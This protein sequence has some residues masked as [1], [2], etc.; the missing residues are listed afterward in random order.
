MYFVLINTSGTISNINRS[1]CKLA[2]NFNIGK[3][4]YSDTTSYTILN[5]PQ[6]LSSLPGINT[7][8]VE[9]DSATGNNFLSF[10]LSQSGIIYIAYHDSNE[11]KK[12]KTIT[13]IDKPEWLQT[14]TDT[15]MTIDV[16]NPEKSTDTYKVYSKTFSP[17]T[18]MLG[19]NAGSRATFW[20]DDVSMKPLNMPQTSIYWD[21][22]Y[23]SVTPTS[24]EFGEI[25]QYESKTLSF[26]I[27]NLGIGTLSGTIYS[28]KDW[29][30][31]DRTNFNGN[32][33]T[34]NVTANNAILSEKEGE[35]SGIINI[36]SNGG[37]RTVT[38]NMTATC[39]LVKPN[40]Y[41]PNNGK[42]A[43]F[44]SGI[45]PNNTKIKIYTLDRELVKILEEKE[46]KKIIE[47]DGKNENG[48]IVVNGIY[49]YIYESPKEKGIGKFTV[50]RK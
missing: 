4:I 49:M 27:K 34:V 50:I 36:I 35:F 18:I 30:E 40:P 6:S 5:I 25:D 37:N 48:S 22:P 7:A 19:A 44:G 1:T 46:G 3:P 8:S 12:I 41:N 47:W 29:I 11:L 32:D 33:I 38:V 39:V 42:L 17:G 2:T 9:V 24:L 31:I 10:D 20:I 21:K 45:V 26:E 14:W 43:F 16:I 15:S 13:G 28:D 23:I